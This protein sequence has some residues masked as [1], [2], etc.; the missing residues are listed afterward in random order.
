MELSLLNVTKTY[1]DVN[2]VDHL[3]IHLQSGIIG[4]L[5]E[6]GAGKT[7]LIRML[8]A[9]MKPSAGKICFDGK[10]IF[11]MDG[12]YR[13]VLGYLPQDFGYYPDMNPL[14]YLGY[15]ASVKAIGSRIYYRLFLYG[16]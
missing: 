6:N 15:I 14:D 1:A 4:L 2:V 5:G 12:D 16:K 3:S 8:T 10:D 7:T 11:K 9:L 13:K